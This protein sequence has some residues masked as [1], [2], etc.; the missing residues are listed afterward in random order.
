MMLSAHARMDW[1]VHSMSHTSACA[2]VSYARVRPALLC[3]CARTRTTASTQRGLVPTPTD[4]LGSDAQTIAGRSTLQRVALLCDVLYYVSACRTALQRVVYCATACCTALQQTGAF[5]RH[6]QLVKAL[7]L[8][9]LGARG[10][11]LPIEPRSAQLSAAA[12]ALRRGRDGAETIRRPEDPPCL[13]EYPWGVREY[14]WGVREYACGVREYAWGVRVFVRG[15][16][17]SIAP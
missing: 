4:S 3:A 8:R 16:A 14:A 1:R 6:E 11:T 9:V 10:R 5:G 2:R 12:M 15:I 13:R 17:I 7:L